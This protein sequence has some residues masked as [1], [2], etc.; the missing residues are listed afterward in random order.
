MNV[1]VDMAGSIPVKKIGVKQCGILATTFS[2]LY[3]AALPT[4]ARCSN[5][6]GGMCQ[7]LIL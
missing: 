5:L 6:S 3:F 1:G 2:S 4:H 7:I